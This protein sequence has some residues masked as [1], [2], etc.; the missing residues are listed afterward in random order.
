M[1]QNCTVEIAD[2]FYLA[3]KKMEKKTTVCVFFFFFFL[4]GIFC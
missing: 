2:K 3:P 1:L 4:S